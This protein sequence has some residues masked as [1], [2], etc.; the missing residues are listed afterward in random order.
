[1]RSRPSPR[2]IPRPP[3][4]S[5][6]LR[7]DDR[8]AKQEE[9]AFDIEEDLKRKTKQSRHRRE[10]ELKDWTHKSL[11][12]VFYI[13]AALLMF[14]LLTWGWH[15]LAPYHLHWLTE[16]QLH[17]MQELM[18]GGLLAIVVRDYI[19]SNYFQK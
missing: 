19:Q 1:M 18:S 9:E 15:L 8:L 3:P 14:G 2:S 16:E 4:A 11:R 17:K 12:Y 13:F 10:E 7:R 6:A 5:R